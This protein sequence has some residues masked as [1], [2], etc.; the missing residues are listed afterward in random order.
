MRE[1]STT[2][3]PALT[4]RCPFCSADP[5]T[6]CLTRHGRELA[7]PHVRRREVH[8]R[9]PRPASDNSAL[10][11][12]LQ[13]R[14]KDCR[15]LPPKKGWT[16][17]EWRRLQ[18]FVSRIAAKRVAVAQ[19]RGEA[20]I[21]RYPK[22]EWGSRSADPAWLR[23]ARGLAVAPMVAWTASECCQCLVLLDA[24]FEER[25]AAAAVREASSCGAVVQFRRGCGR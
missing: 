25:R 8:R 7:W 5:G 19:L 18:E 15:S 13:Q 17:D 12:M 11:A 21:Y 14:I 4:H 1:N 24:F 22:E 9:T 3:H 6:P 2:D 20:V 10:L 16:L 23:M